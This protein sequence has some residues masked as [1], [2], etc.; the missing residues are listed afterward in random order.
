MSTRSLSL[1]LPP[2]LSIP[3]PPR[4]S[5][6]NLLGLIL[7]LLAPA[8]L[9]QLVLFLTHPSRLRRTTRP[10]GAGSSGNSGKILSPLLLCRL[11]TLRFHIH[12]IRTHNLTATSKGHREN[13]VPSRT[14][15]R[16]LSLRFRP[17]CFSLILVRIRTA[18]RILT[19]EHESTLARSLWHLR[20][21]GV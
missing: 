13:L 15:A 7:L 9:L 1:L 5:E 6:R 3:L 8:L 17:P 19:P 2:T 16:K 14:L 20:P 4:E 21:R 18:S 11:T 10:T 12:H